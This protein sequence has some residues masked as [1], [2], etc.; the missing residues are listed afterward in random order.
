MARHYLRMAR[1]WI[2][3]ANTSSRSKKIFRN[4]LYDAAKVDGRT[5]LKS[6]VTSRLP[7]FATNPCFCGLYNDDSCIKDDYPVNG[8][9]RIQELLNDTKLSHYREGYQFRFVGY[10]SALS[11]IFLYLWETSDFHTEKMAT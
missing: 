3:N 6:S 10:A 5:T 1:C 11:L 2:S 4:E 7:F 8:H 9:D